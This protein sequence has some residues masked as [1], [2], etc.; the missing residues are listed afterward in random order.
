[1]DLLSFLAKYDDTLKNSF[2]ESTTFRDTSNRIQNELIKCTADVEM[3]HI[4]SEIK[5]APF[6][7]ITLDETIDVAN[8]SQLSIVVRYVLDGIPQERLLG[9]LD[10]TS[11][12]TADTMLKIV[13]D[14]ISG[15]ECG[16]KLV[17]QSY[18]GAAVIAGHLGGLQSKVKEKYKHAVFVD[19][20]AHRL[21]LVLSRSMDNI[22]VCKV[23]FLT[24]SSLVTF[25]SKS[26]KTTR[27]LDIHV[28][29]RF[30]KVAPTRWNYN[31]RLVQTVFQY[32]DALIHFFHDVWDNKEI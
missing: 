16:S 7:S 23:F 28:Q 9:L 2:I 27:A 12:R 8:L 29:K 31:G 22:K 1:M 14:I 15:L 5:K 21:N 3:D 25:F 18:D 6:V 10:I 32:R 19:C 20:I 13:C 11:E 24:I 17:A 26:S 30:P 4:K